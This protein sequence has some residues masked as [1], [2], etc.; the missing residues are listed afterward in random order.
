MPLSSCRSISADEVPPLDEGGSVAAP[1]VSVVM[2]V[3]NVAPYLDASIASIV[4]QTFTDFEFVIRDDG[5]T[6]GT[7]EILR[8]WQRRDV[9]IRL[10][11]GEESLGPAGSSNFVVARARGAIV[12]RMDG[13]DVAHP[14]R[15][16]RQY[17][18]LTGTPGACLVGALWEGIDERGR[19][20]RPADRSRLTGRSPFAPFPHGTI[21]FRRDA[22]DQVGG[23]RR[24]ADF[25]EDLDLYRRLASVGS[26]LVLPGPLYQHRASRL[27]TRLT[28]ERRTVEAAVDRMLRSAKGDGRPARADGKVAPEVFVSLGSTAV[29]AGHRPRL[30]ARL[31]SRAAL[32]PDLRSLAILIWALWAEISPV[33][34][35]FCL[36]LAARGRD[37]KVAHLFRRE[38]AIVR[39]QP[40][41]DAHASHSPGGSLEGLHVEMGR[42]PAAVPTEAP[43]EG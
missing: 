30:L 42:V 16:L 24:E 37:R 4:G 23:Y 43:S 22:F 34:L 18:A 25:W 13:D 20:V 3:R 32:R 14:D 29:W 6:D 1:P 31:L 39:W 12:A 15:L 36:G 5:S 33:T 19:R 8:A 28:S 10:F 2:T 21:M 40:M 17:R 7:G 26:L 38:G 11:A 35:R 41:P 27:S 9:R